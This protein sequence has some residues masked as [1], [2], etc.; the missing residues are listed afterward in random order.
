MFRPSVA[1]LKPEKWQ[2]KEGGG[3]PLWGTA[4]TFPTVEKSNLESTPTLSREV[5]RNALEVRFTDKS[6]P[7]QIGLL[8]RMNIPQHTPILWNEI[9]EIPSHMAEDPCL[10]SAS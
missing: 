3:S 9:S 8:P 10:Q 4:L 6:K 7:D 2:C 1:Q 5:N